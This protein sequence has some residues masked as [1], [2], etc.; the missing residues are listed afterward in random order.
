MKKL[1]I[2]A[3]ALLTISTGTMAQEAASGRKLTSKILN[4]QDSTY[5]ASNEAKEVAD[6]VLL[7]QRVTGG[8]PKNL[9]MVTPL[10]AEGKAQLLKDKAK[11]DDSTIDN[12]ATTLQL[13]FLA[14]VFEAT[15]D[16]RYRKAFNDGLNYLLSGQ[17]D[18]G[19]WPQFWPN[20]RGYQVHITYNDDNMI[21]VLELFLSI[22]EK[23]GYYTR[24][25]VDD[26]MRARLKKSLDKGIDCILKTQI[27]VDG[28]PTVWCQQ[29]DRNTFVPAPARAFELA[30]Y[31]SAESAGLVKLLM[32]LPNPDARI[33]A[34]VNGAM[35]WFD[36][37]KLT[38]L[39]V[40]KIGK[41]GSYEADVRLIRDAKAKPIWAR[42][43]DLQYCEP[44]VCDR[45][46]IMRR[47]LQDIGV[48]RRCGYSWYNDRAQELYPLYEKWAEKYEPGEKLNITLDS[49]GGNELGTFQLNRKPVHDLADYNAVVNP[50]ESIQKALEAAPDS[51]ETPYKIFVRN[52]LYNQKVIITKPNIVLVGENRDSTILQIG[53]TQK[54]LFMKEYEGKPLHNGVIVIE[55]KAVNCMISG[56]TINNNYGTAV[57]PNDHTQQM[58]VYGTA[59]KTIIVNCRIMSDGNATLSLWRSGGGMYYL[60]DLVVRSKGGDFFCPRG[61]CFAT[62]C[63]FAGSGS[64]MIGHDGRSDKDAKLVITNSIF[65]A[66]KPTKLGRYY[67]DAQFCLINCKMSESINDEDISYAY[68]DKVEDPCPWGKR[69][70]YLDCVREGGDYGFLQN[71]ISTNNNESPVY[72]VSNAKTT[73]KNKW[74]PERRISNLWKWIGY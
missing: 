46:G 3:F 30:S 64:A 54:N 48:E 42:Y 21:H 53:E 11:T 66:T 44:F 68:P 4:R 39:R 40:Y 17:Y 49:K 15:R 13:K 6:Q 56:F 7:F 63:T 67:H 20:P 18:N 60:A 38:G 62:R 45:D 26:A 32:E 59:D 9:D 55:S 58:A 70:Y 71:N 43:Y 52:G 61:T 29:H 57:D 65:T 50:G 28:K 2:Y 1:L 72:L 41:K 37:Y 16:I 27:M 51:S 73:F 35:T 36:K 10:T 31:C 5:L 33:K 19:G 69:V 8:W 34:A 47:S 74:N 12:G 25:L 24:L 23:K 14:G 22:I